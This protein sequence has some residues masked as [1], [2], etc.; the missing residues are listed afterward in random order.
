MLFSWATGI[1][2]Q[3]WDSLEYGSKI[4]SPYFLFLANMILHQVRVALGFDY[5]NDFYVGAAPIEIKILKYF[6]SINV[7][8]MELFGQSECT[9][10]TSDNT[11]SAFK[12]GTVGRPLLGTE[13]KLEEGTN[14]LYFRGRNVCAGYMG[15]PDKTSEIIDDDGWLHSGDVAMIDENHDDRIPKPS[16]FIAIT[17]RIK[18]LIITAGGE[19]I[20]PV[21]I[22]DNLKE[23]MNVLSN[24]MVIGDRRKFL[25]V[26][27]CLQ[28]EIDSN[29]V[30]TNKLTGHALDTSKKIGS[31]ATTTD[32]AMTCPKWKEYLDNG[33]KV[34]NSK[35]TSH[36]QTVGK[37]TL[38]S[39]DFTEHGG[40]LTST[41]KL[42]R[43]VTH[44]KYQNE[45]NAIYA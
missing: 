5:C 21:L 45:I 4:S 36:A 26:L 15:M 31:S 18:E 44:E 20:P 33:V 42:K 34:A 12:I 7:P 3:H 24:V 35:A 25:S 13:M 2:T 9:G 38:L 19:N 10:V 29:G 32:E 43:S 16:G 1:A 30:A 8:I 22:E 23:A 39:T 27:L 17:G 40:E 11:H 6:Q 28:V 14:E 37:W 41:S